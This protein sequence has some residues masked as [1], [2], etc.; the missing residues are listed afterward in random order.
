MKNRRETFR[1]SLDIAVTKAASYAPAALD[2]K[3]DR[4]RE[5]VVTLD[6]QSAERDSGDEL[7]D[8]YLI[9]GDEIA[10]WDLVH[11][12]QIATTG[13][14]RYVA[15]IFADQLGQ[16]V[17]TGAAPD[18]ATNDPAVL[19]VGAAAANAPKSLAAGVARHG[20][21][22]HMLRY[23]LVVAGTIATGIAYTVH[24]EARA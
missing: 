11:F 21:F 4:F 20:P 9:T 24:V 8:F 10:E 13:A 14:K 1:S 18:L 19:A 6:I 22:G 15:R 2:L 7:Y 5:L 12:P 3:L 23:E 17:T 16:T